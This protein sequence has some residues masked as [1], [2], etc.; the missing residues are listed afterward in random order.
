MSGLIDSGPS[1]RIGLE[2]RS[3]LRAGF[4][5]SPL[6]VRSTQHVWPHPQTGLFYP[7]LARSARGLAQPTM[8][9]TCV[10]RS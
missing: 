8:V 4:A 6:G 3:M 2:V 5:G 10:S 9:S 1:L 7:T